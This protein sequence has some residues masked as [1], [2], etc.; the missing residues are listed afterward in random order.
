QLC[1][2]VLI[3]SGPVRLRGA[4]IVYSEKL[5]LTWDTVKF[6]SGGQTIKR[7]AWF[8]F[9]PPM[10]A[11]AGVFTDDQR[12]CLSN[13][14]LVC[15]G[16]V[17]AARVWAI[18]KMT[19]SDFSKR[20]T[21]ESCGITEIGNFNPVPE[22]WQSGSKSQE[23]T[24]PFTCKIE[25]PP[26]PATLELTLLV[27]DVPAGVAWEIPMDRLL[28]NEK[29]RQ[30][31]GVTSAA[32]AAVAANTNW[33]RL[34]LAAPP[35][36]AP[37]HFPK[38]VLHP[39][40]TG[41]EVP[42]GFGLRALAEITAVFG[43]DRRFSEE[44]FKALNR[45]LSPESAASFSEAYQWFPE[46]GQSQSKLPN[47]YV[48]TDKAGSPTANSVD[49][50][51]FISIP[52]GTDAFK[53]VLPETN[54]WAIQA[55]PFRRVLPPV[56]RVGFVHGHTNTWPVGELSKIIT[57]TNQLNHL[58]KDLADVEA[59]VTQAVS[60]NPAGGGEFFWL[61]DLAQSHAKTVRQIERTK[62]YGGLQ[63]SFYTNRFVYETTYMPRAVTGKAGV[64][65]NPEHGFGADMDFA[66]SDWPRPGDNLS[67]KGTVAEHALD[68][69]L[70]YAIPYFR[71]LDRKTKFQLEIFG[72][73]GKDDHYRLGS[74]SHEPFEHRH[75]DG[76]VEHQFWH[77][78]EGWDVTIR[79]AVLWDAH[80]LKQ[81]SS[82]GSKQDAG[83]L[84]RD[85]Q[86]WH[87]TPDS[88]SAR[89]RSEYDLA[90]TIAYG[91]NAGWQN[92][93]VYGQLQAGTKVSFGGT[94]L[95]MMYVSLRGA[96]GSSSSDIPP[97]LL[98]R[99]G[100]TDRL[101]GLEPGEF[102]GRSYVHGELAYGISLAPLLGGLF[103]GKDGKSE[104]PPVLNGLGLQVLAEIGSIS[105]Q[106][107]FGAGT[108]PDKVISSYG[109]ALEKS[110]PALGGAGFRL[111]YAW[112]PDSIRSGGRIFAS[113][114]WN[115]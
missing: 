100:D 55:G 17:G 96:F 67:V 52:G 82:F 97:A 3:L 109:V 64:S 102:S 20:A 110:D 89:M 9:T 77:Q 63:S 86:V 84:L 65:Y 107:A 49:S 43:Q 46:P 115:F 105:I 91:P 13:S 85:R 23:W 5:N 10:F 2:G 75:E 51:V 37:P 18:T 32:Q 92:S 36:P 106:N 111:G 22:A 34:F 7:A 90:P 48:K 108:A 8:T 6:T 57:D 87:F 39:E 44:N 73:A 68:G 104:P 1:V 41:L 38:V 88:D 19:M 15:V 66:V 54:E 28:A 94:N 95:D 35:L 81:S 56:A 70:S 40:T 98:Y 99:L 62:F 83:L 45:R 47:T 4:P 29:V 79:D 53:R 101:F 30:F 31:A 24:L 50:L 26:P 12:R 114:N 61:P 60:K 25:P 33:M 42:L 69:S 72:Q 58:R 80:E 112:S 21:A 76:G 59:E 74:L 78:G 11:S 71:S 113:L 103:R 14:F 27:A 93:F 16:Q